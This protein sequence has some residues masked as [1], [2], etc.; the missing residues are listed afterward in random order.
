MITGDLRSELTVAR[1]LRLLHVVFSSTSPTDQVTSGH[2]C[3]LASTR[4]DPNP[5]Q[6]QEEN[7]VP[8]GSL[9]ANKTMKEWLTRLNFVGHCYLMNDGIRRVGVFLFVARYVG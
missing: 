4:S 5:R 6:R 8:P 2:L 3:M 1:N 7:F 9:Q